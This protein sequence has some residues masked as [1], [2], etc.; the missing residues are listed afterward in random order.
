[1][2]GTAQK[3]SSKL[4]ISKRA[5]VVQG[6]SPSRRKRT[7]ENSGVGIRGAGAKELK[8]KCE[9]LENL[10]LHSLKVI[11]KIA[12]AMD[13]VPKAIQQAQNVSARRKVIK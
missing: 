12:I 6:D 5:S 9:K 7:S 4:S 8:E 11:E 2:R 1:M 10:L 13:G 3:L